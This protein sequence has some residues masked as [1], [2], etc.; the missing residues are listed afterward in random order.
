MN[1][2]SRNHR[3]MFLIFGLPPRSERP[4][5]VP[6]NERSLERPLVATSRIKCFA[7]SLRTPPIVQMPA[8][9]N[10]VDSWMRFLSSPITDLQV[11]STLTQ[12]SCGHKCPTAS[13]MAFFRDP[14]SIR[15][16]VCASS[17]EARPSVARTEIASEFV[18]ASTFIDRGQAKAAYARSIIGIHWSCIRL[19]IG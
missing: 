7:K 19:F 15:L 4:V 17:S 12:A 11:V 16:S 5:S 6:R 13:L 1:E 14:V 18:A 3:P 2:V 9:H 10:A 8:W